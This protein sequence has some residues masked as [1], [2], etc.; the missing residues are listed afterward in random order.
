GLLSRCPQRGPPGPRRDLHRP[1]LLRARAGGS[2]VRAVTVGLYRGVPAS[3]GIAAGAAR[4]L[5][6]ATAGSEL[7]STN[8][9]LTVGVDEALD[10]V[11]RELTD[12][13]ARLRESGHPDEAEIVSVGALI[14][15]D[16]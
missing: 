4:V 6:R 9:D 13:A 10:A 12:A 7:A 5:A 3:G 16:P 15:D 14:A 11:A 2:P 8:G 1:D